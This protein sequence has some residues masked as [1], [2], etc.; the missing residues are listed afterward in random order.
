[1]NIQEKIQWAKLEYNLKNFEVIYEKN[2]KAVY[3]SESTQWGNIVLKVNANKDELTNE[4]NMIRELRGKSSCKV[5][6][7]ESTQGIL[8]EEQII[9]G[10][11]LRNEKNVAVRV[12][13]FIKVFNNI[14]KTADN[15]QNFA[16]YLDWLKKA[17]EFC[18]NNNVDES[19]KNNMHKAHLIGKELFCKYSDRVLLH[20]DLHHDNML[21][22]DKGVYCIIDPK[23]V[24]G[25]AIFD[26]P[27]Y[28]LNEMDFVSNNECKNHIF[29][30]VEMISKKTNYLFVDIL[31]L[32][33]MEVMLANVWCIEDGEEHDLDEIF[34]ALELLNE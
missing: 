28:I 10:T 26:L 11:V 22:N 8:I 9:P 14:H 20:G 27:R 31:K 32:L 25:P 16:S 15:V 33:F 7:Y 18:I 5:L 12:N 17:Y 19:I 4:Y 23:G 24:I 30:V 29:Q 21:L 1:M 6:A 2:N 13:Q 3:T 34:I